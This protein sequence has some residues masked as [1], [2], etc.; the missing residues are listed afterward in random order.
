MI[1]GISFE[2]V[3]YY[4]KNISDTSCHNQRD[5]TNQNPPLSQYLIFNSNDDDYYKW[6]R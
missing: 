5:K 4:L 6:F 2:I 1:K 3:T